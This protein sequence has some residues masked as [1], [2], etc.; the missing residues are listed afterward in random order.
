MPEARI[1]NG[2]SGDELVV[3]IHGRDPSFRL[4][5][6]SIRAAAM[7][8]LDDRTID[9]LEI[10]ATVFAA[11]SGF[12][13]G[14]DTRPGMGESWSRDFE[15]RI[16]V[17]DPM[18]WN[19]PEVVEALRTATEFLTGDYVQF[20]FVSDQFG[21]P[22]EPFLDLDP[23][24]QSF[25]AD[26]VIMFSG[27]LDSFAG[28]LESLATTNRRVVLVTHR[29]A[30]KAIPRQV[31]LG[32]VLA[33]R[34][35]DQVLHIHVL[36]RRSG[37]EAA[38][39]TQRSRT[40]LFTALGHAVARA[41]GADRLSFYENGI[42][43]QNLPIS[44]QIAGT[45]ATRTTHPL[46]LRL[47]NRV[48]ALGWPETPRIENRFQWLT[49]TEVVRRIDEYGE[50]ENIPKAVSCTSIRDQTKRFTHCGACTQ[51][52][53][54]RFAI[55]AAR[56][57]G[58]DKPEDYK[59]DVLFGERPTNKS[60]TIA[61]EWTRHSLRMK[62]L[63][64]TKAMDKFGLEL[65]RIISGYPDLTPN[66]VLDRTLKMQQR[67]SEAV[68]NVLTKALADHAA[69]IAE[70]I[71]PVSCLLVM[72]AGQK[73][74][75]DISPPLETFVHRSEQGLGHGRRNRYGAQCRDSADGR[76]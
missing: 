65:S 36:A 75:D 67:H 62:S 60:I 72:H 12:S 47:M 20:E 66:A 21:L 55:L 16:P 61:S 76:I 44:E 64:R 25:K 37:K 3:R 13:R 69:D 27:G 8:E 45:M 30:Q 51:C 29:S 56:L 54:R 50:A 40:L 28:A 53:D 11:D 26:E 31:E 14:G 58:F 71:L 35:P 17:R 18:F 49:K 22:A 2:A 68:R 73:N 52:L 6:D 32:K 19:Q 48:L 10:A 63:D 7:T 46:S 39:S 43:S 74:A 24:G 33:D 5:T 42:V 1:L 23:D 15:V 59:T 70:Q 34:F 9:F 57:D 41:F 38:D 4:G